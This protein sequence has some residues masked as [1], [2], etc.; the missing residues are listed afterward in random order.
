MAYSL[1]VTKIWSSI[2]HSDVEHSGFEPPNHKGAFFMGHDRHVNIFLL[3]PNDASVPC[4]GRD[5][6]LR[7][8]KLFGVFVDLMKI[9]S[10]GTR[11]LMTGLGNG[12]M[13][14]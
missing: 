4:F 1:V 2:R 13:A 8:K 14:E 5:S 12:V 9:L 11:G 6:E 3:L 7:A 10:T